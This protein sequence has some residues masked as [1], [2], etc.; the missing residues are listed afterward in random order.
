MK[1]GIGHFTGNGKCIRLIPDNE[2]ERNILAMTDLSYTQTVVQEWLI[3]LN[4]EITHQ[5]GDG[6]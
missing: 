3:P 4:N 6:N 2:L 1:I 5:K